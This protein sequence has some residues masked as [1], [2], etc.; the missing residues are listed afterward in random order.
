M[1]DGTERGPRPRGRRAAEPASPFAKRVD[2]VAARLAPALAGA[3]TWVSA[4][5]AVAL[6]GAAAILSVGI[7]AGGAAVIQSTGGGAQDTEAS[8]GLETPRPTP[9]APANTQAFPPVLPTATP[10]P[11]DEAGAA[12]PGDEPVA[13]EPDEPADDPVIEPEP[14]PEPEPEPDPGTDD[15]HPGRGQGSKKPKG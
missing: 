9:N 2:A 10:A 7:I 1:S 8:S 6:T 4:H 13:D 3:T 12:E 15:D 5:R 14:T 11:P